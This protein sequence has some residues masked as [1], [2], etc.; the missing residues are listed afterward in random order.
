MAETDSKPW[1]KFLRKH[2]GIVALFA[3]VAVSAAIGAVLVFLWFLGNA[4][5]TDLVPTILGLWT[6][7]HLV[8]FILHAIFWELVIIGIPAII[9]AIAG[10]LWW[11]RLPD[12][13]K[14][15][16]HML[17]TRSRTT[18]GGGGISLL[19]SIAFCIK[20]YTDGNWNVAFSLWTFNYLVYSML[21]TLIWILIIFGIPAALGIIWW[22]N[23]E[24][25]KKT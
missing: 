23:H 16:Y 5:S 17:G 6:M 7:N 24:T 14:A 10:W 18:S 3:V 2:W 12:E 11:R 9:A 4:Q 19:I 15:E 13:E 20:V 22:I 8:T 25:K 1:K 21:W